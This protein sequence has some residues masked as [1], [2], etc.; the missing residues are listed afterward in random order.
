MTNEGGL[1]PAQ[2][3]GLGHTVAEID[4]STD[5]R[6]EGDAMAWGKLGVD[7]VGIA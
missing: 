5:D 2:G 7:V 3:V 1:C 6:G 4:E